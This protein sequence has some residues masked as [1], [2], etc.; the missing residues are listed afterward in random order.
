M[1]RSVLFYLNSKKS[2]F[3]N[4]IP[5]KLRYKDNITNKYDH[6]IYEL[7]VKTIDTTFTNKTLILLHGKKPSQQITNLLKKYYLDVIEIETSEKWF[8]SE[9]DHHWNCL[10]HHNV[11]NLLYKH[12]LKSKNY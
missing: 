11:A 5:K 3:Q 1:E 10:G 8:M 2:K 9:N 6:L 7:I 12:I 4:I